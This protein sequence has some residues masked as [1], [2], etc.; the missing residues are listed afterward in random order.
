MRIINLIHT[1]FSV[2]AL[3]SGAFVLLNIKGTRLHKRIGYLYVLSMLILLLTSFLIFDLFAG[4]GPYH[5]LSIVSLVTLLL[6]MYFP[7][8]KRTYR[9]WVLQHYMWMSYSY[10]GLL[11]AGG[12]HLFALVPHWPIWLSISLFWVLP[13]LLGSILIFTRRKRILQQLK[14]RSGLDMI[15]R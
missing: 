5:V 4:F 12:S 3:F 1:L 13:Y 15:V 9:G 7:L 14:M 10:V 2:L 6:G 8:F 11:M